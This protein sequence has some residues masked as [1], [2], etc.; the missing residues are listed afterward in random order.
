MKPRVL[1]LLVITL[2]YGFIYSMFPK[3]EFGFKSAIDPFY[4]SISTMTTVGYGDIT[5]KSDRAKLVVMT[6]QIVFI[7]ELASVFGMMLRR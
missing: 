4:F 1:G 2:V 7:M 3:D 6:Q 5:P